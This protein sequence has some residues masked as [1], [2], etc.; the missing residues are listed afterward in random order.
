MAGGTGLNLTSA[1]M[2]IHYDPWWN[3]AVEDQATDRAHRI[4]QKKNVYVMK[5]IASGTVEEKVLALQ[6]RKQAVIAATVNTTDAAVMETLT[7]ED[8]NT[9]LS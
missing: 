9:L 8:L 4:G 7:A 2:V 3:P 5:M 6:R 1:D